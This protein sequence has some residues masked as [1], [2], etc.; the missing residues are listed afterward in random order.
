MERITINGGRKLSGTVRVSGAKN[1]ALP[2]M[3]ASILS[4]GPSAIGNVPLLK[5]VSTM[6]DILKWLGSSIPPFLSWT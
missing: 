4:E 6:R 3:A 1:A 2:I 5:D